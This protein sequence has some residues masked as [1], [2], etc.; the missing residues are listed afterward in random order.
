MG[1]EAGYARL[2]EAT[3]MTVALS[4]IRIGPIELA[5]RFVKTATFEG[6]TPAGQVSEALVSHHAEMARRGVALTT[7]AYGAVS[8]EGRTFGNQLLVHADAGLERVASAVRQSCV[9]TACALWRFHEI[10]WTNADGAFGW[11]KYVRDR[12]RRSPYSADARF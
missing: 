9:I 10:T 11:S 8:P 6:M 4:P 12:D 1:I 7:V 3:D 2:F 5:N